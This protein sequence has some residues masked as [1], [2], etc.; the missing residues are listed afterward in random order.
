MSV[1]VS[2]IYAF[3]DRDSN[4]VRTSLTSLQKQ[5]YQNFEVLFIDYGSQPEYS[6]AVKTTVERFQFTSYH[7]IAHEGLLWNKSKALNYGIKKAKGEYIFIADVDIVFHPDT[8]KL[9]K[10]ICDP[11]IAYLFHLSYLNKIE[12]NKIDN[13]VRFE[14]LTPSH[15]GKV[16]GMILVHKLGLEKVHGLDEFFHFYGSEDVDLFERL[17]HHG[18]KIEQRPELYFK[19]IWHE[20]YNSYDDSMLSVV[21]RLFNIKRINQ[22]HFFYNKKQRLIVPL[23]QKKWGHVVFREEQEVLNTPDVVIELTNTQSVI[24]HFFEVALDTYNNKTVKVVINEAANY[25]SL[26]HKIKTVLK[27]Q[28]QPYISLKIVNDLI[29]SKI[30]YDYRD[31]NYSYN[32]ATNFKRITFIIQMK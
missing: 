19:H 18:I 8:T 12:S 23:D 24:V 20:I 29:L 21:P 14:T 26:K 25:R 11:D 4:R 15:T 9:F 30:L 32:V 17:M 22:Q 5:T 10:S 31:Y 6:D 2:I 1:L 16:N 13:D 27:K 3:R 28:I 7:Y